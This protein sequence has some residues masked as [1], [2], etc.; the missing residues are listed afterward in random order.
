M[1][2]LMWNKLQSN[3]VRRQVEVELYNKGHQ[4]L[5]SRADG[6]YRTRLRSKLKISF[7]KLNKTLNCTLKRKEKLSSGFLVSYWSCWNFYN[8]L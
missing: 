3:E 4:I 2:L 5:Y 6:K 1:A 8:R 7:W